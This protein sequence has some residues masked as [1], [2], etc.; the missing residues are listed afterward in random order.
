MAKQAA[1]KTLEEL[2]Q[3]MCTREDSLTH[4]TARAEIVR[5]Q[6]QAQLDACTAL[7]S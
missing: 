2:A 1:E 6:T 4:L 7:R 3:D 5:R